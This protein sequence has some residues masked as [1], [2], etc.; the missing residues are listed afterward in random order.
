MGGID[1][2]TRLS[3]SQINPLSQSS[4]RVCLVVPL[5]LGRPYPCDGAGGS[6]F[7]RSHDIA[8][9]SAFLAILA[10]TIGTRDKVSLGRATL[11]SARPLC[12]DSLPFSSLS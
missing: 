3:S 8:I 9:R 2:P 7:P 10:T 1:K 5:E 4:C 11:D 6:A 12:A